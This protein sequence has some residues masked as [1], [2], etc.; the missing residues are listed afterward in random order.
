MQKR[1]YLDEND[2]LDC[3]SMAVPARSSTPGSPGLVSDLSNAEMIAAVN[4]WQGERLVHPLT[5]RAD[6]CHGKLI[7]VERLNRVVL[8]CPDCGLRQAFIPDVVLLFG[9]PS[10][11]LVAFM[12]HARNRRPTG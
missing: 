8:L 1:T 3:A 4:R 2:D 7:P 5:C 12:K 6:N 9:G 10:P 11:E